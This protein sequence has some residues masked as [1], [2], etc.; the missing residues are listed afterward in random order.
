MKHVN[1]HNISLD[2]NPDLAEGRAGFFHKVVAADVDGLIEAAVHYGESWYKRDGAGAFFMLARKWDRIENHL[3]TAGNYGIIEA[4]R[5]DQRAEGIIDDIRDLRRYLVLVEAKALEL[6][7]LPDEVAKGDKVAIG[8]D[9][10]R[11]RCS[12]T[13]CP[14]LAVNGTNFCEEHKITETK[15]QQTDRLVR[16][17]FKTFVHRWLD[18][19][20]VPVSPE[21]LVGETEACRIG[22]RLRYFKQMHTD[23][24][25][26]MIK[27]IGADLAAVVKC[28]HELQAQLTLAQAA[29]V[30]S[31]SDGVEEADKREGPWSPVMPGALIEKEF[32]RQ[33]IPEITAA[34]LPPE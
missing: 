30:I 6:G 24:G 4:I 26:A 11:K 12:D 8:G 7:I 13:F 29:R 19:Q 32:V 23:A 20:G 21:V 9:L 17:E 34:Q 28:N 25:D 1:F 22:R 18:V 27:V 3:K 31:V 2:V 5:Q 10:H 14:S 16:E 33:E 15:A